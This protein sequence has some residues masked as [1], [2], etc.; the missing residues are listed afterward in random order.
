MYE[1]SNIMQK[2]N[3]NFA[4]TLYIYLLCPYQVKQ[5][6]DGT[7][8]S[9]QS[10]A[11]SASTVPPE[12]PADAGNASTA[13]VK[14]SRFTVISGGSPTKAIG[15]AT[16]ELS[17]ASPRG[18]VARLSLTRS[19]EEHSSDKGCV[20]GTL[21]SP[22]AEN[23]V[24]PQVIAPSITPTVPILP[25]SGKLVGSTAGGTRQAPKG[26]TAAP[27]SQGPAMRRSATPPAGGASPGGSS[28]PT[29][30]TAPPP[31]PCTPGTGAAPPPKA[32]TASKK[33]RSRFTVKT[34][35]VEVRLPAVYCLALCVAVVYADLL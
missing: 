24:S 34:I 22:V 4:M 29:Q 14:K 11:K 17:V 27:P 5:S 2:D 18:A 30:L 15:T 19:G 21:A 1:A 7:E 32:H 8:G 31:W 3:E 12:A 26:I 13:S 23:D 28:V 6:D 9:P 20:N 35:S 25:K 16:P 33:N 10:Q